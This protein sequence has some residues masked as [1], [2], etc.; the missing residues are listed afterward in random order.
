MPRTQPYLATP[1]AASSSA[2]SSARGGGRVP[3]W[4]GWCIPPLVAAPV[5]P[6]RRAEHPRVR[7]GL[8]ATS[9]R[10][11]ALA[12][13]RGTFAKLFV[14]LTCSLASARAPR[15]RERG[16]SGYSEVAPP[17]LAVQSQAVRVALA[18]C[19]SP[20]LTPEERI[21]RLGL[22]T[23]GSLGSGSPS[24][25]RTLFS[26]NLSLST[27]STTQRPSPDQWQKRAQAGVPAPSAATFWT[28]NLQCI[29]ENSHCTSLR[30]NIPPLSHVLGTSH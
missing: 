14:P 10:P 20:A 1:R 3:R 5:A 7:P 29:P 17:R 25:Q 18:H 26:P 23:L 8:P 24:S 6:W 21:L 15:T 4:R 2:A 19:V 12:R 16:F 11:R 22:R 28:R 13:Y 27:N 30:P 9:S